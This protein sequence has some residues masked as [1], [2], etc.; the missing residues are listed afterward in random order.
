MKFIQAIVAAVCIFP[1]LTESAMAE[2]KYD[3]GATDS[4]IKIGNIMPYSGP[5][6]SYGVMG[7]VEAAY[8][9]KLNDEGG[10]NGRKIDFISYDD[11]YSPPKAVEQAR[12]LVESDEVLLIFSSTGTPSNAA[13]QKY[14]NAKRVPQLFVASYT[15]K[16]NDPKKFPWTMMGPGTTYYREGNIFAAYLVGER[17]QAK[18]AVLYQNDDAGKEALKGLKAGLKDNLAM[19]VAENSYEVSEPT[20]DSHVV[21]LRASGAD[22]L[23]IFA[24]NKF[25]AQA[26]RKVAEIG[27]KPTQFLPSVASSIGATLKPAGIENAQGIISATFLKDT[28]D[29]RWDEDPGMKRY[30]EFMARYMPEGNLNDS[31]LSLG[32][33]SAQVLEQ[34]LKQAGDD[35]RRENIMRQAADLKEVQSD[36]LLPGIT[37]STSPDDFV[38]IKQMHLVRFEGTRWVLFDKIIKSESRD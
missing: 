18:I 17:P 1:V 7:K 23:M 10:I 28:S 3:P 20:I 26:I 31:V 38:P 14:M 24:T 16:W 11:A 33:L 4:T 6:S 9:R 27:W 2:K 19:L 32:Y 21:T 13:I 35:L 34:V 37:I 36:I 15:E 30:R 5:A 8:F 12:K 25:A 22:T 29:S